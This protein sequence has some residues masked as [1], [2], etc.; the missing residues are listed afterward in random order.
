MEQ[1]SAAYLMQAIKDIKNDA[2]LNTLLSE[3]SDISDHTKSVLNGEKIEI[4]R[5]SC[6]ERV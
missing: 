4:G 3:L 2:A 6:R 5:A 1:F